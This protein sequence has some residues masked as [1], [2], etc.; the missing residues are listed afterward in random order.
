[1]RALKRELL[2]PALARRLTRS[3]VTL[4]RAA[5]ECA[6]EFGA[7]A[8]T[9]V[10]GFGFLGHASQ[11]AGA[12]GVTFRVTPA[13]GW[14]LPKV[15]DFARDG[16]VPGGLERNREFYAPR[17]AEGQV[18]AALLAALYDPQTSGGLLLSVPSRRFDALLRRLKTR[19]VT[20]IDVG[21]VVRRTAV[22]VE[23]VAG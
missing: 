12:S 2:A 23:I 17:V 9:D 5:A 22:A 21:V 20:A 3:M 13:L 8:A 10:T 1:M 6:V 15:A 16:V 19:R 11:M 7:R 14:L 4:N 18:D